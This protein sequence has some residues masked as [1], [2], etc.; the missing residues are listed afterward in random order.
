M[1]QVKNSANM[2]LSTV[3]L[4]YKKS[5]LT[6]QC[7]ETLYKKYK[8]EFDRD[9]F[10]VIVVD[11]GSGKEELELLKEKIKSS[12]YKNIKILTNSENVGFSK[13]CNIGAREA[14]GKLLLFL[15]N[16]TLIKDSGISDMVSYMSD[17]PKVD[18]MGGKLTNSDTSDQASVGK[19]Y[20]PL[21]AF[22][23]LVGLQRFGFLGKNPTNISEVDW[24]KGGC[25]MVKNKVFVD[26]SGFDENIFMYIEDMEFCYRA[27]QK[28]Y[29]VFF[30]PH[31]TIEH[32]DQ[33]S[34]SRSF[35]I[36]NI[37][38]NLLYFYKKHRS[39]NEYL[40]LRTVLKAKA[41][42][43]IA[44]GRIFNNSY[45]ISTYEKAFKLA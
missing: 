1:V 28:G 16:D 10:E 3:I 32:V 31:V 7:L 27:R 4:N 44:V 13:G 18:I 12:K 39:R 36:V 30:Y 45:L 5:H 23:L 22:L 19:F 35:A 42:L 6:I 33:G 37:Y 2:L 40:F 9:Q 17:H 24:V 15:N 8:E 43:L 20:T 25:L 21:N 41:A 29:L 11:N 26:L 14:K 38:Q 34:S